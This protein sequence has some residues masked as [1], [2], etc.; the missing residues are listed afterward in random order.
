MAPTTVYR[1]LQPLR[2]SVSEALPEDGEHCAVAVLN[3]P[4]WTLKR[5]LVFQCTILGVEL[6]QQRLQGRS[7]QKTSNKLSG[8]LKD[9]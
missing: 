9:S 2:Q 1:L 3:S 7:F 5:P 8:L 6:Y 4:L